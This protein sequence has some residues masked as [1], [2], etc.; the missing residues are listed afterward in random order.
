MYAAG[1]VNGVVSRLLRRDPVIDVT[2]VRLLHTT[3]PA[4]HGKAM[5]ELGWK[6]LETFA[7]GI[8]KTVDWYL[9]NRAWTADITA[10][11][12][13]RERLGTKV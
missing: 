3:S 8:E 2:G 11:K 1:F 4:N 6:P 5:R 10:K 12:Y 13:S 7:T 9:Q